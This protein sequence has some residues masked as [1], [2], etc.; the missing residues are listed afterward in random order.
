M[1]PIATTTRGGN[2][3]QVEVWIDSPAAEVS[4]LAWR[5]PPQTFDAVS[6]SILHYEAC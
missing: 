4:W 3:L 5:G 1:H 6:C 2:W